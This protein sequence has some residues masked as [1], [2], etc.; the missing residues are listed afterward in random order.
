[1]AST[2]KKWN[3]SELLVMG[4]YATNIQ[5]KRISYYAVC[6]AMMKPMGR[7][8]ESIRSKLK[9]IINARKTA[10]GIFYP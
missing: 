4:W 7:S 10:K 1:M 3:E 2:R 5:M 9:R 8:W 6:K